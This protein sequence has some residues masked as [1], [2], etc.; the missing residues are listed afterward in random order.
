MYYTNK[1][2]QRKEKAV[3]VLSQRPLY[4]V[5]FKSAKDKLNFAFEEAYKKAVREVFFYDGKWEDLPQ[6]VRELD[7]KDWSLHRLPGLLKAV[8]ACKFCYANSHPCLDAMVQFLEDWQEA[9]EVLQAAKKDK[10]MGRKPRTEPRR[11]P[12]RT[13]E[14]TGTCPCCG[15]NVK[16]NGGRLVDHGFTLKF[17]WRNGMCFGVNEQPWEVSPEGKVK[18]IDALVRQAEKLEDLTVE[19]EKKSD[20]DRVSE[21]AYLR[22]VAASEQKL[23]DEW[24]PQTLPGEK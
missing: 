5:D 12:E 16:M 19:M 9:F 15:K 14:N 13:L 4:N 3:A 11:T 2:P 20:S 18:Y 7:Y 17:G 21:A 6:D 10:V 22:R 24:K 8:N 1:D 23:V